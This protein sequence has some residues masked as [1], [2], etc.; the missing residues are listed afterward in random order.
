[1]NP[2]MQTLLQNKFVRRFARLLSGA[3]LLAGTHASAMSGTSQVAWPGKVVAA[4]ASW[5]E[6]PREP[7]SKEKGEG[8]IWSSEKG[9]MED[10]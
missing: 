10:A 9:S 2:A 3:V 6:G 5:P 7:F 1:M 4:E 8:I